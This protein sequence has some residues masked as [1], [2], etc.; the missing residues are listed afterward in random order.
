MK[1]P[2]LKKPQKPTKK[3]VRKF[4]LYSLIIIFG[5]AVASAGSAFFIVSND[6]VMGGAT[7]IGILVKNILGADHPFAGWAVNIT[8]Y[9]VDIAMFILGAWLLGKKFAAGTLAGTLLYPSFLALFKLANDAYIKANGV[10]VLAGQPVMA[11][12][13]GALL[14]GFGI[15]IVVRFGAST[16]G[17]DIP[18][19]IF[20][21]Y[22]NLPVSVGIWGLDILICLLQLIA[23]D[24][25][26]VLY[27]FFITLLSGF[28]VDVVS[29]IGMKRAQV[30]II[31]KKYKEIRQMILNELNRGVTLLYGKTG[32]LQERTFVL[33]TVVSNRDVVKLK[34]AVQAIDPAAFLMVSVISEVR[35]NGFSS[36]QVVLPKSAAVDLEE[37]PE[38]PKE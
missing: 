5:N 16:G 35:G 19:L 32:F 1:L 12:I 7:G 6:F 20:H 13:F 4:L 27:G 25:N 11:A 29:P 15:G 21:K 2:K 8:V 38:E 33:M 36:D 31:S 24:I 3:Q 17:T 14:F 18:P 23:A 22:F 9:G 10:P 34:N 30:M 28:I 37:I 26:T